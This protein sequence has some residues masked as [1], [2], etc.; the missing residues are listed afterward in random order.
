[1]QSKDSSFAI[2]IVICIMRLVAHANAVD[3]GRGLWGAV[4]WL[5]HMDNDALRPENT[6]GKTRF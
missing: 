2:H 3:T 1:M 6:E 4:H 5:L